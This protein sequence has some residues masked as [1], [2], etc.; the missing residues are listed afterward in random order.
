VD[1]ERPRLHF[2]EKYK[3]WP[4]YGHGFRNGKNFKPSMLFV[5]TDV[6]Q[7]ISVTSVP[8]I[9]ELYYFNLLNLP[10]FSNAWASSLSFSVVSWFAFF[11]G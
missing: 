8:F 2:F 4:F 11:G 3:P 10:K 7:K 6:I 5:G 9:L 1:L